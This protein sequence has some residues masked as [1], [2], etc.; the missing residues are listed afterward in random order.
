MAMLSNT[1]LILVYV[2]NQA[3]G[4]IHA[5]QRAGDER[6]SCISAHGT[7]WQ[8]WG[9]A[10]RADLRFVAKAINEQI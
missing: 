2:C 8:C 7:V 9:D 10:V 6:A 4:I 5:A 1:L 3:A